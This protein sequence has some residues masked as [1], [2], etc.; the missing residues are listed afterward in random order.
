MARHIIRGFFCVKSNDGHDAPILYLADKLQSHGLELIYGGYDLKYA[1]CID[2][3]IEEGVQFVG[4]SSYNGGHAEF[5]TKVRKGLDRRGFKHVSIIAGGGATI[6]ARDIA[7]LESI[8]GIDRVFSSAATVEQILEHICSN[9][10]FSTLHDA[11]LKRLDGVI[12]GDVGHIATFLNL[13]EEKARLEGI[14]REFFSRI[15]GEIDYDDSKLP[16]EI[17][18]RG[19]TELSGTGLTLGEIDNRLRELNDF[20]QGLYERSEGGERRFTIGVIGRGGS[21]KSTLIDE[22]VFRF[23]QENPS[24]KSKLAVLAVD[25]SNSSGGSF[26]KERVAYTY[27]TDKYKLYELLNIKKSP[28]N[29]QRIFYR[30]LASRGNKDGVSDAIVDMTKILHAGGYN[31]IVETSGTGQSVMLDEGFVD[32]P[33]FVTTPDMGSQKQVDVENMLGV[34]GVLVVIN[35]S[36]KIG[37]GDVRASIRSRVGNSNIIQTVASVHNNSGIDDLYERLKT[38]MGA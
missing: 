4:I 25:P 6:T 22:L 21:G 29:L 36:D 34:R 16:G 31:V 10:D 9:Y 2:A 28:S 38:Y 7:K 15:L 13:A 5:F 11:Y 3:A 18:K 1:Q 30:S 8:P 24:S 37:A 17:K 35:K 33:V 14:R 23:F 12:D 20:L 19:N 26:L 32:Q 27:T